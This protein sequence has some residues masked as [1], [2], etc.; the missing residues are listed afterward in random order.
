MQGKP[1]TRADGDVW[2]WARDKFNDVAS[3]CRIEFTRLHGPDFLLESYRDKVNEELGKRYGLGATRQGAYHIVDV[4][5]FRRAT[6]TEPTAR[7]FRAPDISLCEADVNAFLN[8][9]VPTLEVG[10]LVTDGK[11][12]EWIRKRHNDMF[13]RQWDLERARPTPGTMEESLDRVT[14]FVNDELVKRYGFEDIRDPDALDPHEYRLV[15]AGAFKREWE[16][17]HADD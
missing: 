7:A 3:E 17:S 4:D 15:D 10:S 9:D 1:I 5:A 6:A 16:Q 8:S 13:L 11:V 12:Y 2:T 14:A